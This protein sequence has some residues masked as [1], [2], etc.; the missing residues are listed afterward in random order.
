MIHPSYVDLMKVMNSGVEFGEEPVVNSRYSIVIA[1]SKRARQIIAGDEPLVEGAAGKKP[2]AIAID[3]LYKGK[4][5]I[6]PG[7]HEDEEEAAAAEETATEI[8]KEEN[9][10]SA[11]ESLS[12][13][14]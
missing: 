7:K 13:E 14:A 8:S 6:L 2:L 5:K 3:E 4:V 11:E 1:A 12:E 9:T 10:A